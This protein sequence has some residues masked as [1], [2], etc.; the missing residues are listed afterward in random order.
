MELRS[1]TIFHLKTE[2]PG[3]PVAWFSPET[4]AW[5][6]VGWGKGTVMVK[7]PVWIQ[8]SKNQEEQNL[9]VRGNEYHSCNKESKSLLPLLLCFS[10]APM[11][12]VMP[13]QIGK[14]D[15]LYSIY[16]FKM[17]I[18]SI[19]ILTDKLINLFFHQISGNPLSQSRR[20]IKLTMAI[21]YLECGKRSSQS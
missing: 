12:L 7:V 11:D 10:Q 21:I 19:H 3:K 2:E 18:S 8:R 16:R 13:S 14:V 5:E 20:H 6:F 4:K 1:P 9:R 15:L 17:L